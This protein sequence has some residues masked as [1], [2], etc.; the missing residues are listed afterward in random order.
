MK[1]K[2]CLKI[3]CFAAWLRFKTGQ[4]LRWAVRKISNSSKDKFV[5]KSLLSY[6]K[7]KLRILLNF[8]SHECLLPAYF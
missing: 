3:R 5:K 1:Y 6:T 8:P 7:R 2:M 4:A